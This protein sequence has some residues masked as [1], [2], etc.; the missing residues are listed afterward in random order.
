MKYTLTDS[1][2]CR[3]ILEKYPNYKVFWRSGYAFKGAGE[4]ED[5]KQPRKEYIWQ[6]GRSRVLTFDE[7]MERRYEWSAAIDIKI[8]ENLKEIHFN[9]FSE[10]DLY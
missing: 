10:N 2:T 6:E 5:D 7:R 8:D 4:S 3:K 1:K 9:G